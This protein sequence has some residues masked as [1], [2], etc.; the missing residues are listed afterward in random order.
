VLTAYIFFALLCETYLAPLRPGGSWLV[1]KVL[2]VAILVPGLLKGNLRSVQ[3]LSL[4]ILAY[5]AEGFVRGMSDAK[6]I[7]L[8]GWIGA[9]LSIG[10]FLF[11]LFLAKAMKTPSPR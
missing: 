3:W 9:V 6:S 1:L 11:S 2:P 4:I 7:Q 10:I 5:V 8:Y